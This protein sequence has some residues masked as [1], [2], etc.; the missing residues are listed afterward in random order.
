MFIKSFT[1]NWR[2]VQLL[3]VMFLLLAYAAIEGK[4]TPT[5]Y[6]KMR[7]ELQKQNAQVPLLAKE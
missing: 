6:G 7:H 4:N 1:V 5:A 2:A 3:I